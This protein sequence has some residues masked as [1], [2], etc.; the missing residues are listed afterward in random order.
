MNLTTQI[1][2]RPPHIPSILLVEDEPSN[3]RLVIRVFKKLGI[4]TPIVH[5]LHAEAALQYL[6]SPASTVR[7][8][9]TDLRLPRISGID[10]VR[11]VK[12]DPRLQK[13]SC[14]ILS[15]SSDPLD[16]SESYRAGANCFL[17]K[18]LTYAELSEL[19]AAVH[20]FFLKSDAKPEQDP[21]CRSHK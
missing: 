5:V 14:A 19:L 7:L 10:L 1:E 11:M 4:D 2:E 13:V 20:R 17:V 15:A 6:Q 18:P 16:V 8:L 12:G 3:A 21:I 9:M